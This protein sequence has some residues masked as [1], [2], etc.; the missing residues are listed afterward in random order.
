MQGITGKTKPTCERPFALYTGQEEID[1]CEKIYR[2]MPVSAA[3]SWI[4]FLLCIFLTV[5]YSSWF[6]ILAALA[7]I[8]GFVCT[9]CAISYKRLLESSQW[10]ASK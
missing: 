2:P 9:R 1:I 4:A 6:L 8:Y 10:F 7:G 5:K 3:V